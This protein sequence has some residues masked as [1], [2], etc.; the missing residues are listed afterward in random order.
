ME[1]K[2]NIANYLGENSNRFFKIPAY[3]RGYKWGLYK[4]LQKNGNDIKESDASIL[5]EDILT[6]MENGKSEYFIQGVTV[7]ENGSDVV[8]IDGQQRTT[9][10][11][12]LLSL[13]MNDTEK[14]KYLFFN[15][16][17]K[18]KY[19]I[20]SSSHDFLES[21][22]GGAEFNGNK[23]TQD[24]Y[25]FEAAQSQMQQKFDGKDLEKLK[26]YILTKVMLFY[27][28][29]PEVK[30]SKVFSML[31][32]AKAFM[33]TDELI[34]AEFL[35][36]ASGKTAKHIKDNTENITQTLEI[37]KKQIGEDWTTNALRSQFA[38]Q[39]DKWLYWWNRRD[40]QV[41][42]R[43]GNNPMGLLLEY[44]YKINKGN[45]DYSNKADDVSS[46]FKSFQNLLVKDVITAKNN[47]ENLRKLQ[48]QFEDIF[49]RPH[50]YNHLGVALACS[51]ID[52]NLIIR[53]FL[54]NFKD[55]SKIRR[56]TLLSL[57]DAT[58]NELIKQE[59]DVLRDKLTNHI[60]LLSKKMVY[61]DD[62]AKEV[63]FR[64][65]FWL[66]VDAAN[67]RGQKFEFFFE[68]KGQLKSFYENRSLE[69][70]WPKSR[71][72]FKKDDI[73]GYFC[74]DEKDNVTNA[75]ND[76]TGV[77]Y[78]EKIEENGITEHSIGNL[79][80]LHKND[81][82]VFSKKLPEDKKKEYFNL[83]KP[84]FSRNLLHTMSVFAFDNWG[85]E[86]IIDNIHKNQNKVLT[87][88]KKQYE[89]YVN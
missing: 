19:D 65:L 64:H 52:K 12:L 23:N 63:A 44:F 38:R 20:R 7:Y 29:V 47:F 54:T 9:T 41:F 59:N 78:R 83:E 8:L 85:Q 51:K 57:I 79:L 50:F 5:L 67:Q 80:F 77:L 36:K 45:G 18:L 1:I 62:D 15:G 69:H 55:E 17:F 24:I 21:I 58:N 34:K 31:N 70:I 71:V 4:S 66:N 74:V 86:N 40:V 88:I 42:F 13:L 73:D 2:R 60:S 84:L 82:S 10:L 49:N 56:Y 27:I 68:D 46:V 43:S 37:L 48:K 26:Q 11:F 87:Q 76:Q 30:A 3:Q 35:I 22:C 75:T 89:P 81:N 28:K 6:A 72:L 14:Q 16:S 32:G 61:T 25:F 33:K 39:W 53:Y